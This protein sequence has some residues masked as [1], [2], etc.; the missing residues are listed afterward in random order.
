MSLQP[1]TN[2]SAVLTFDD[3]SK[4]PSFISDGRHHILQI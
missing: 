3:P 1:Q 2:A 4:P